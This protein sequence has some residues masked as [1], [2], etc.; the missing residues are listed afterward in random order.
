MNEVE[1]NMAVSA[2]AQLLDQQPTAYAEVLA[3]CRAMGWNASPTAQPAD[4]ID[5]LPS[6]V[7]PFI[8]R[9]LALLIYG[10][11][12]SDSPAVVPVTER[13]YAQLV[14][15]V[16]SPNYPAAGFPTA[17]SALSPMTPSIRDFAHLPQALSAL[18]ARKIS[19][20]PEAPDGMS[21]FHLLLDTSAITELQ[22][23]NEYTIQST[24]PLSLFPNVETFVLSENTDVELDTTSLISGFAHDVLT[25]Y[26]LRKATGVHSWN[27]AGLFSGTYKKVYAYIK[28]MEYKPVFG[29]SQTALEEIYLPELTRANCILAYVTSGYW[30]E[31]SPNLTKIYVPKLREAHNIKGT[32]NAATQTGALITSK[33]EALTKL[34]FPVLEEISG[35]VFGS[36]CVPNLT[37]LRMPS[38]KKVTGSIQLYASNQ[39]SRPNLSIIEVGA[40]ETNLDLSWW[41]PTDKGSV[42]LTNFKTYI[43]LR[44]AT[45]PVG[46]PNGLT[47]TL[48]QAVYTAVIEGS[49]E[50]CT[51]IKSII[52]DKHWKVTDG[53]NI[54]P[55]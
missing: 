3:A 37:E 9:M 19:G 49:S 13:C 22:D 28:E 23:D 24:F 15:R 7:L 20:V 25:V 34:E 53:T 21:L 30:T 43:A 52:S 36:G 35:A 40:M 44:L 42:F 27:I 14:P 47:L 26:G 6:N 29:N 4:I 8:R 41:N 51:Q 2:L 45:Q 17:P 11:G 50:I 18:S 54:Y 32:G 5:E 10:D 46:N 33:C 48:S 1:K 12:S 55:Q 39:V 16:T 38:L 31:Q